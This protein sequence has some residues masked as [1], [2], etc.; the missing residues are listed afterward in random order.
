[1]KARRNTG[2]HTCTDCEREVHEAITYYIG[3]VAFSLC[4]YCA[5]RLVHLTERQLKIR[6]EA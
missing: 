2:A 6:P 5:K 4:A 3:A 1:M